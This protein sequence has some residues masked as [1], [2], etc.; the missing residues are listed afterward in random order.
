MHRCH[1]VSKLP[2]TRRLPLYAVD[3]H[4]QPVREIAVGSAPL[5]PCETAVSY[6]LTPSRHTRQGRAHGIYMYPLQRHVDRRPRAGTFAHHLIRFQIWPRHRPA[7]RP[8]DC[9]MLPYTCPTNASLRSEQPHILL[10]APLPKHHR[11]KPALRL[12]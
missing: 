8:H 2:L 9:F 6:S 3:D 4:L 10:Q 5:Q 1:E 11:C 12:L 7:N